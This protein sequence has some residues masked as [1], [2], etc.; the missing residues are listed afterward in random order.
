[1][2]AARDGG[3]GHRLPRLLAALC[4]RLPDDLLTEWEELLARATGPDDPRVTHYAA[5]QPAAGL[6]EQLKAIVQVWR[7]ECPGLPG[8]ALALAV[9]AVRSSPRPPPARPVVSG[10]LSAAM[11]GR[12]TRGIALEVIRSA[13]TSLLI[14][15]FAAHGADDVVA[16][17]AGAA[18][19]GV[20]V[21][22]LLEESTHAATAFTALPADVRVWHRSGGSG[23]LHAKLLAADRHTALLGSANLTDRGLSD[24]IEVGVVLRDP[25]V[26][27]PL[28]DHFR[29]LIS[30]GAGVM[31]RAR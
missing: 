10:P 5:G 6:A 8:A 2:P 24:N 18:R 29:W 20:Q 11:P 13:S 30:P 28:V 9:T 22:L 16:A 12:L 4:A 27:E 19:R 14:A 1:M 21:D 17:T 23:V 3:T 7:A 15:S 25:A 26:V 31:R